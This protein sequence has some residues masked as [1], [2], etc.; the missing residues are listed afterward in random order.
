MTGEQ[1]SFM[2]DVKEFFKQYAPWVN[3][4]I[5][6]IGADLSNSLLSNIENINISAVVRLPFSKIAFS[7]IIFSVPPIV[8]GGKKLIPLRNYIAGSKTITLPYFIF[9]DVDFQG[10]PL[11]ALYPN[12]LSNDENNFMPIIVYFVKYN[13]K[14]YFVVIYSTIENNET[15]ISDDENMV[16]KIIALPA[17][18]IRDFYFDMIPL[19]MEYD[20]ADYEIKTFITGIV[21]MKQVNYNIMKDTWCRVNP[22]FSLCK[23]KNENEI[24]ENDINAINNVVFIRSLIEVDGKIYYML[25]A[26][27][28]TLPISIIT[29][30]EPPFTFSS[31]EEYFN[32]E[33]LYTFLMGFI[34]YSLFE[35]QY[36][37]N[38]ELN[39][40]IQQPP[41]IR[42]I[43]NTDKRSLSIDIGGVKTVNIN[44]TK[45]FNRTLQSGER[46]T[47]TAINFL[48]LGKYFGIPVND[49]HSLTPYFIMTLVKHISTGGFIE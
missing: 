11:L 46:I 6:S 37:L 27:S 8:E 35:Q 29:Y 47:E 15:N 42:V 25:K 22:E 3:G 20:N 43:I 21:N 33:T 36:D 41:D 7:P 5:A 49:L 18:S 40:L 2:I 14:P 10:E 31:V 26:H 48:N 23:Y 32:E 28:K 4:G 38:L 16:L 30:M 39:G 24:S 13:D 1:V 44:S 45:L 9:T 19:G 34:G 17:E 12:P